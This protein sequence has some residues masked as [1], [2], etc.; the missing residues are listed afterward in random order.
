MNEPAYV[1]S[2]RKNENEE[3]RFVFKV[4][5]GALYFDIRIFFAGRDGQFFP[6][7]KGVT[8]L[9]GHLGP[10]VNGIEKLSELLGVKEGVS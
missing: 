2:F 10:F 3:V 1:Y 4:Y 5:K 6:T 8:L 7:K 9:A